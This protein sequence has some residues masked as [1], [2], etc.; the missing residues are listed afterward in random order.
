MAA[1]SDKSG[2]FSLAARMVPTRS[3]IP[4]VKVVAVGGA[5]DKPDEVAGTSAISNDGGETWSAAQTPP[6][7]YRSAV[8][9]DSQQK[10][11]ITVGPN[12]TDI[13]IDDG[14]NWRALKPDP[15][16]Q[17]DADKNWNALSLPFAVGPAGRIGRLRPINLGS[18]N[19]Q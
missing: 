18:S 13:S 6:H 19:N 9:Y 11:W 15:E 17:L 4:Q 14:H 8:A 12:G 10:L 1:G 5:Y 3:G 16:D 7:G 2:I